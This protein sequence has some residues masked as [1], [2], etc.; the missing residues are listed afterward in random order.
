LVQVRNPFAQALSEA[1]PHSL[2]SKSEAVSN[3]FMELK[4]ASA[5][6]CSF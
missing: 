5:L 2:H 6:G 3:D 4:Q 1:V